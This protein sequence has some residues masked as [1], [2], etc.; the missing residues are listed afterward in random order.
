MPHVLLL[1]DDPSVADRLCRLLVARGENQV[2]HVATVAQALAS[3]EHRPDW[4]ILDLDLPDGSGLVVLDAIR[5]AGHRARIIV[6]SGTTDATTLAAVAAYAPDFI[7]P[8]PL[9]PAL[10]PL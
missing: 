3:L 10:L 5:R 9:D 6:S 7:I 8:K 1:E 2:T 4:V